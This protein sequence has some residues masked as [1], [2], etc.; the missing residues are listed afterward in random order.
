MTETLHY[1]NVKTPDF[2]Q[3]WR[4]DKTNLHDEKMR[5]V[6]IKTNRAEQVLNPGVFGVDPI[7]EVFVPATNYNLTEREH[8]SISNQTLDQLPAFVLRLFN[9]NLSCH[10][11]LVVCFKPKRTL[12]FVGVV[13][14]DG[15]SCFGDT[16]LSIFVHQILEVGG[17][18]LK[19]T[20]ASAL[21][22][23]TVYKC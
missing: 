14:R 2:G 16:T 12:A 13:K 4:E 22:L 5:V 15:Y 7:D 1:K 9:T 11:D 19:V 10:C 21:C 8:L 18:D 6:D 17:S 3:M 23:A 20:I